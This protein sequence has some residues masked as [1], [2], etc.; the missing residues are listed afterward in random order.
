MRRS[1]SRSGL[2]GVGSLL[3]LAVAAW[4]A[5]PGEAR[6]EEPPPPKDVSAVS[7]YV[8][9]IPTSRGDK[10]AGTAGPTAGRQ[11]TGDALDG[12]Q[13]PES[14]APSPKQSRPRDE[15]SGPKAVDRD[16]V[17]P[18]DPD[19]AT[20]ARVAVEAAAGDGGRTIGFAAL[21]L[22]IPAAAMV[23]ALLR[24]RSS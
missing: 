4:I 8:E 21:L 2:R 10:V 14:G 15:L 18:A 11:E 1:E 5:T 20:A 17:S 13:S 9:T 7:Q 22:G 23:L 24:R 6:A 19:V 12:L 16:K 3:S